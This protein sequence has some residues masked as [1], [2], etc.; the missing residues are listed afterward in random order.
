MGRYIPRQ[1]IHILVQHQIQRLFYSRKAELSIF[2]III[3]LFCDVSR[4]VDRRERSSR[5]NVENEN[6]S[7]VAEAFSGA[8]IARASPVR[9][10]GFIYL[11]QGPRMTVSMTWMAPLEASISLMMTLESSLT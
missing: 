8:M 3:V 2:C 4:L 6:A 5:V 7:A 1:L 9:R 11:G 10:Q